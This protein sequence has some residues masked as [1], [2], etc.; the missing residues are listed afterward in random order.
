M[1]S[2]CVRSWLQ[3]TEDGELSKLA[4]ERAALLTA[5]LGGPS[6]PTQKRHLGGKP[7]QPA[8]KKQTVRYMAS[9]VFAAAAAAQVRA[10][11][12]VGM[13]QLG[14]SILL[15]CLTAMQRICRAQLSMGVM[16]C[17]CMYLLF[18][19]NSSSRR[20]KERRQGAIQQRAGGQ[21][22]GCEGSWQL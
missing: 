14:Q 2:K 13:T 8:G 11:Q 7:R 21:W 10:A 4:E 22:E 18:A 16:A 17:K 20:Q 12:H 5:V 3:D 15:R 1:S 19:D 6:Q 9:C